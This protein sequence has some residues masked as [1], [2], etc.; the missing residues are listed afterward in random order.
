MTPIQR[1][2]EFLLQMTNQFTVCKTTNF[3]KQVATRT[4]FFSGVFDMVTNIAMAF[5][6]NAVKAG[7][8]ELYNAFVGYFKA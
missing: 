7:S 5:V 2:N 3:A 6:K 4:S 8:S 1:L